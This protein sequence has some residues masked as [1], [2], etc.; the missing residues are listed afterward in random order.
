MVEAWSPLGAGR[1]LEN[2]LL[3]DIAASYG[4]T[5]A[6]LCIRW[7]LQRRAI[8]L[9]GSRRRAHLENARVFWFDITDEDLQRIEAG[10]TPSAKAA[11]TPTPS[12][13]RMP[14]PRIPDRA[15]GISAAFAIRKP[16]VTRA[17][18]VSR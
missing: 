5:V 6:Q 4:C 15:E 12:T 14:L 7:C 1:V 10:L 18:R 16:L 9:P 11:S 3:I 13:S 2:Q 8:P 17:F